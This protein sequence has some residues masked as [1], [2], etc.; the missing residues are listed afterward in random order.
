MILTMAALET[1]RAA[2]LLCPS[3]LAF[4]VTLPVESDLAKPVGSILATLALLLVHTTD[5]VSFFDDPSVNFPVAL[6]CT[7]SPSAMFEVCGVISNCVSW[8]E[9]LN[10]ALGPPHPDNRRLSTTGAT[11]GRE[12]VIQRDPQ[13]GLIIL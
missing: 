11:R 7:V 12:R 5:V 9:V 8:G 6:N 2:E 4:I 1:V 10:I 13:I 3:R